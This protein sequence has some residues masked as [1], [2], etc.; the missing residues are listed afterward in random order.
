MLFSPHAAQ[1]GD[2][3]QIKL[4]KFNKTINL[5]MSRIFKA[6]GYNVTREQEAI[7]RALVAFD[8]VNQA[9]LAAR[10]GQ[11]RNNLSRTLGILEDKGFISRKTCASDK[12]NSLVYIT[13]AGREFHAHVF[14]AIEQYRHILFKG[15][16]ME[17]IYAFSDIIQ[18]LTRNLEEY[19]EGQEPLPSPEKEEGAGSPPDSGSHS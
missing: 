4:N 10:T 16:T 18:L 13:P 7:L 19:L 9:E 12:R 3:P 1:A 5:A 17:Q 14:R 11:E 2:Y 8:G 15:L 6:Y